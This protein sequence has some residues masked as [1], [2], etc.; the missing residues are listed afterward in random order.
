M[1]ELSSNYRKANEVANILRGLS[2]QAIREVLEE[3]LGDSY[4]CTRSWQ[5][6]GHGTMSGSDFIPVTDRLDEIV[7][8]IQRK[9]GGAQ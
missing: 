7:E 2:G 6:W 8:A 9:L 5:A 3:Y 4:D 1:S